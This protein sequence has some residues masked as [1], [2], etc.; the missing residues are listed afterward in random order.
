M[1]A[2]TYERSQEITDIIILLLQERDDIFGD[3]KE[4]VWH[5]MIACTLRTDKMAPRSQRTALKIEGIRG[6]K[7]VLNPDIKFLIHG[8]KSK[9]DELNKEKK[10]AYVANMLIRIDF[11][12]KDEVNELAEK[13]EDFEFGKLRKPDIQDFRSFLTAPGLGVDWA[14]EHTDIVNLVDA[15]EVLV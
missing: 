1:A 6:A 3:L 12:S 9:W 2:P 10:I 15:K 8:Y 4:H 7:T 14:D 5:E 11:P 13:G